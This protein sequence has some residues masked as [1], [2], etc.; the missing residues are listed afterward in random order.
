VSF[1]RAVFHFVQ[2]LSEDNLKN[3]SGAK[4]VDGCSQACYH[5]FVMQ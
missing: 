2:I 4:T 3:F 5:D 1:E